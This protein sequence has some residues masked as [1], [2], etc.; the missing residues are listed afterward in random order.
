MLLHNISFKGKIAI[1][2]QLGFDIQTQAPLVTTVENGYLQM[3]LN[4]IYKLSH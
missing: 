4:T 1:Q 3:I 2:K